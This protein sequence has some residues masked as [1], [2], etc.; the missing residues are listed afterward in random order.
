MDGSGAELARKLLGDAARAR[1][2]L[3]RGLVLGPADVVVEIVEVDPAALPPGVEGHATRRAAAE[4]RREARR[5]PAGRPA[6]T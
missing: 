1:A 6:V 3:A 4:A 2:R 5:Y